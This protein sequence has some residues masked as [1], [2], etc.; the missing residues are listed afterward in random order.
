MHVLEIPDV[1]N[2]FVTLDPS[3]DVIVFSSDG[4]KIAVAGQYGFAG[5]WVL[6]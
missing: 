1:R 3:I 6:E 2:Q 4:K 5:I